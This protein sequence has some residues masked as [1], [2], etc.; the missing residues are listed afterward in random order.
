MKNKP[1][2][3]GE[4][5]GAWGLACVA[6]CVGFAGGVGDGAVPTEFGRS[7]AAGHTS[8]LSGG[9]EE[10]AWLRIV[11]RSGTACNGVAFVV[12]GTARP[13]PAAAASKC[14]RAGAPVPG[15]T[16]ADL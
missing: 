9:P 8:P 10:S 4:A 15:R 2:G 6:H 14:V 3:T 7:F 16:A 11:G 12:L 13:R 5:P 1:G